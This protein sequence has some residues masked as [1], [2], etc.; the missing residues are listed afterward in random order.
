MLVCAT[1]PAAAEEKAD[2]KGKLAEHI[3]DL[4]LTDEQEAKIAGIRKEYGPKAQ[5]ACKEL[6]GIVKEEV[7][8]VQAV[9]TP[10]QKKKLEAAKEERKE[11]RAEG[12]AQRIARVHEVDLTE[13]EISKLG[14][15]RKEFQ[16]K[17][18]KAMQELGT[19]L[20]DEQKKAREEALKSGKNRKEVIES[21][22]LT[23]QQK[24]KVEAI[25]KNLGT[26]V[27][28][29]MEQIRD[30]LDQE[31]KAQL[32]ELKDERMERARDRR[33]CRIAN[34]KDLN[35][36]DEQ[37]TQITDVRKE[38]R[39]KVHEAGTK[40]RAAI[41]DEVEAIVAVIKV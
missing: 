4:N 17:I 29:E 11:H 41:R 23:D 5:E 19:I 12:L 1:L 35:L 15:I 25:G 37:K 22:K 21:L 6:A 40:A 31:Q 8:K 7:E 30:V 13:A 34:R 33:A 9:L 39:P 36:T 10:D 28:E 26:L 14:D 20:S 32:S 38:F 2:Q 27:R 24:Q 18:E 16:P 3:Q